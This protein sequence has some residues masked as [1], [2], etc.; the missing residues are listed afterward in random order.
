LIIKILGKICHISKSIKYN[1]IDYT[2]YIYSKNDIFDSFKIP[3]IEY[4]CSNKFRDYFNL[5]RLDISNVFYCKTD[6]LYNLKSLLF[7]IDIKDTIII[8]GHSDYPI[9]ENRF[10][11][12]KPFIKNLFGTNIFIKI[13]M[14][15]H[16]LSA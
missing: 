11:I 16:Y 2:C 5:H 15:M 13:I 14:L 1:N 12:I 3:E 6:F 7:N 8:T 10:N 9:D 4:I